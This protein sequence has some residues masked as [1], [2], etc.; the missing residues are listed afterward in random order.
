MDKKEVLEDGA[1]KRSLLMVSLIITII[2]TNKIY[3]LTIAPANKPIEV[4]TQIVETKVEVL[5]TQTY[6]NVPLDK[7]LQDYIR[8]ECIDAELDMELV[9]AIMKVESDF[10]P[11]VISSTGDFGLMQVNKINFEEIERELG[12]TNMLDPYQGAKAGI[13]L[14]SKLKW[15]ESE[16][17]M[18]MAYNIGVAGA[19]KLWEQGIYE[20]DY[21]KKVLKAKELIGGTQYEITV[22]CDQE[23]ER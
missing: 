12:L 17:Q 10:N 21:S 23:S 18:L 20:T 11:K 6:Y 15:N 14:L 22:F 19:Q 13:Y 7:E 5:K 1:M 8:E 4:E 9:L 2:V 16:H 3:A